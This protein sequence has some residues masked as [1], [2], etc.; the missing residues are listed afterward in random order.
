MGATTRSIDTAWASMITTSAAGNRATDRFCL[1]E[2]NKR[3]IV[4]FEALHHR[5]TVVPAV[6][7]ENCHV[8]AAGQ[9]AATRCRS[10]RSS[11]PQASSGIAT[12]SASAVESS[13]I[14][15]ANSPRQLERFLGGQQMRTRATTTVRTR[16]VARRPSTGDDQPGRIEPHRAHRVRRL[17]HERCRIGA[18]GAG[19]RTEVLDR[20]HDVTL[21]PC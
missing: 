10:S 15:S 5:R 1:D 7:H 11:R 17:P 13:S 3:H 9:G 14:S 16:D 21:L 20:M 2:L 6:D 4:P 8:A 18:A 12:A 19:R